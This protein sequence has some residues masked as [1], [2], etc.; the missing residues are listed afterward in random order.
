[1]A[2]CMSIISLQAILAAES[3]YFSF[4]PAVDGDGNTRHVGAASWHAL[5]QYGSVLSAIE[6][7]DERLPPLRIMAMD[8]DVLCVG[9]MVSF[10]IGAHPV[11]P[12]GSPGTSFLDPGAPPI[13][14]G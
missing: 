1:M 9:L 4:F 7:I 14:R 2:T 13:F 12:D 5:R 11:F 6:T 8:D 3:R 10:A